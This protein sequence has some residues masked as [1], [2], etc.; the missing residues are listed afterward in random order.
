VAVD[1]ERLTAGAQ[2]R[3]P[4][5]NEAVSLVAVRPGPFWEFFFDGP[6]GP[7]KHVLAESELSSIEVIETPSE[8]RFDGDPFQFRLGVE[9]RRI[10]IAFAYEMAAV[11]VSNIQ[12]LP[13]QLE[14]WPATPASP[15]LCGTPHGT[16]NARSACSQTQVTVSNG[17]TQWPWAVQGFGTD[18]GV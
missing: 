9:A 17:T 10:D 11:A 18:Y 12:P 1:V 16:P 2:V 8:L 3:F 13:H 7:G 14:A 5:R 6:S 15:A 4:G